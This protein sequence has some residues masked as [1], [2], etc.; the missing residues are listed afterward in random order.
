MHHETGRKERG[1]GGDRC[2]LKKVV[3]VLVV[4]KPLFVVLLTSC[5]AG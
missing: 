5:R 2:V 3:V 4:A 1:Y